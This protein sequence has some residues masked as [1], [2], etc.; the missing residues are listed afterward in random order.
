[1][2]VQG[3]DIR[4]EVKGRVHSLFEPWVYDAYASDIRSGIS[5]RSKHHKGKRG[6]TEHALRKLCDKMKKARILK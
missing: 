3:R 6:A 2:T 5:A 1:M 4:W